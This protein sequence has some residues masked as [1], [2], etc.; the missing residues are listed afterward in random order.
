MDLPV[1]GRLQHLVVDLGV[2][3]VLRGGRGL[4]L[5]GAALG[6]VQAAGDLLDDVVVG[7]D[8]PA[9]LF[10]QLVDVQLA[11]AQF[12]AEQLVLGLEQRDPRA[13]LLEGDLVLPDR[14]LQ[15]SDL[16][17]FSALRDGLV[18]VIEAL[19]KIAILI[20]AARRGG[21]SVSLPGYA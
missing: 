3:V 15:L 21:G 2:G 4:R 19:V 16:L 1:V 12:L 17:R 5:G 20:G 8:E 11:L 9:E 10:V 7:A 13:L 14:V 6:R 18:S